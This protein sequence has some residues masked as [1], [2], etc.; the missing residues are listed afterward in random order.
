MDNLFNGLGVEVAV[1]SK[2]DFL[3]V[4][5]TLT[6]IGLVSFK[7]KTVSQTCHLLHKRD[8]VTGESRYAIMHFKEMMLLDGLDVRLTTEDIDRRNKIATMLINWNMV[9]MMSE[10]VC[11]NYKHN[12]FRVIPYKE[13]KAWKLVPKYT[14]NKR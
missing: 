13:K 4:C 3:K 1:S 6:R 9:G 10:F 7:N 14:F 5:E 11:V 2:D 12:N 8:K